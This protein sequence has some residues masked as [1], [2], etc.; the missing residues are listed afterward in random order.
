M[1]TRPRR[2]GKEQAVGEPIYLCWFLEIHKFES[3]GFY[4]LTDL[5]LF[6]MFCVPL[7]RGI[8][9]HS[10]FWARV[11]VGVWFWGYWGVLGSRLACF[12]LCCMDDEPVFF[13]LQRRKTTLMNRIQNSLGGYLLLIITQV[14]AW[15]FTRRW[16][17]CWLWGMYLE[18]PLIWRGCWVHVIMYDNVEAYLCTTLSWRPYV[19][20][21]R[22]VQMYNYIESY[23]CTTVDRKKD[24]F[25][26]PNWYADIAL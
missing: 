14:G 17:T 22:I 2:A 25:Y 16:R 20:L 11:F 19:Q 24:I 26:W 5:D 10:N 3:L 23:F 18:V 7:R 21:R 8:L 13:I 4:F 15:M 6:W 9:V 12:F 1:K